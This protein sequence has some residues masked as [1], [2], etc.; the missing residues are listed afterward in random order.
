MA[1]ISAQAGKRTL[2]IDADLRRPSLHDKLGLP[3]GPTLLELLS[4]D[5]NVQIENVHGVGFRLRV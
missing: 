4:E 1:F 3:E 5:E 2:V